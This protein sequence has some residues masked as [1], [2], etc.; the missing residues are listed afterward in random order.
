[1]ASEGKILKDRDQH[2]K[3]NGLY[4]KPKGTLLVTK[5]GTVNVGFMTDKE[6]DD[7]RQEIWFCCQGFNLFPLDLKKEGFSY[8]NVAYTTN[9]ISIGYNKSKNKVIIAVR[10]SSNAERAIKTMTNLGCEGSAICLDSGGSVN[11]R[12]NNKA[13]FKTSRALSNVIYWR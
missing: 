11:L 9:R 5:R 4:D 2:K 13:I 7:I 12:I 3:F 10:Q 6:L 1:M 8:N